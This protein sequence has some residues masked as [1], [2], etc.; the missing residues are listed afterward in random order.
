MLVCILL[1]IDSLSLFFFSLPTSI[2]SHEEFVSWFLFLT[3]D[4]CT[5][6]DKNQI[7]TEKYFFYY[8]RNKQKTE[9]KYAPPIMQ[10]VTRCTCAYFSSKHLSLFYCWFGLNQLGANSPIKTR[11]FPCFHKSLTETMGWSR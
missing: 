6:K 7:N 9:C 10:S 8:Y 1:G 3:K 4:G 2:M 5:N 11:S